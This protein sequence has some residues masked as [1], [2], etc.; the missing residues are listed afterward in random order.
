MERIGRGMASWPPL[1]LS[2]ET[3]SY[4]DPL[5]ALLVAGVTSFVPAW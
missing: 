3:S 2:F 5:M 4:M 1:P